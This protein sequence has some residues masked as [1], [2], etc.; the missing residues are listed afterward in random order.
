M[1][2]IRSYYVTLLTGRTLE[3]IDGD[4][5]ILDDGKAIEADVIVEALGSLP[6]TEWLA[7]SGADLTDGVLVDSRLIAPGARNNFV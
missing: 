2:A 4:R 7:G 5:V 3:T 6:N 1:Y